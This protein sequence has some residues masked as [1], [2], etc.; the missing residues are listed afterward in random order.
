MDRKIVPFR[1]SA[2]PSTE[3]P[4]DRWFGDDDEEAWTTVSIPQA[5]PPQPRPVY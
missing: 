4:R 1:K 5:Q 2:Q 3:A